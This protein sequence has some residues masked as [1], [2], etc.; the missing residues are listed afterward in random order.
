M[1][2]GLL[3][4]PW[5]AGLLCLGVIVLFHSP[6]WWI[7]AQETPGSVEWDRASTYL[8]QC[9]SPFREDIEPAARWRFVPQI[10]VWALGG[11][12][13][14]ALA[15]PWIGAWALLAWLYRV[16]RS[17]G[18][19]E[20]TSTNV[21]FLIGASA[22]VLVST[23]WLGMNDAW[24][25]LGLCYLGFGRRMPLVVLAGIVCP[26]IDER[27]VFGIP[28]ALA[29][30]NLEN[31]LP[32]QSGVS[33]RWARQCLLAVGP[34]AAVRILAALLGR[35]AGSDGQF[36]LSNVSESSGYL[37]MAPLG[38]WMAFRFAY[39]PVMQR[40]T[41]LF[42]SDRLLAFLLVFSAIVPVCLGFLIAS[43]TMRTAGILLPL[44]TWAA[45][46]LG[47][48]GDRKQLMW[49]AIATLVFTAAHVTHTKVFPINSLPVELWRVL[50]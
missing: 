3:Q 44:C 40:T 4:R 17:R 7:I 27:F 26:F 9:E 48:F 41:A 18:L 10:L 38:A 22:P 23:G 25:G 46:E 33:W 34:Y 50:R 35:D 13:T 5:A 14:V 24:M 6:R 30:R 49:L 15:I 8:K 16:S 37:W 31:P 47:K 29:I 20:V 43:D 42:A 2:R 45:V 1:I 11:N 19:D 32:G 21:A 36:L 28:L 39:I 12:R